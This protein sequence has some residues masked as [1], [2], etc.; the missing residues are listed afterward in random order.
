M[1][2]PSF[3]YVV[4]VSVLVPGY[5][6]TWKGYLISWNNKHQCVTIT[7]NQS[8]LVTLLIFVSFKKYFN[9]ASNSQKYLEVVQD[10]PRVWTSWSPWEPGCSRKCEE[11][12][13]DSLNLMDQFGGS[14]SLALGCN[15]VIETCRK[16][17]Y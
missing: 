3:K 12:D 15:R 10:Q 6:V 4:F 16:V 2:P 11:R 17:K 14:N 1:L 7:E 8:W 9:L 5:E 13:G